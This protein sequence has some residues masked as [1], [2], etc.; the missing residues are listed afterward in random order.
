MIQYIFLAEVEADE[1][2]VNE[3]TKA[4]QGMREAIP[5]IVDLSVGVNKTP[6]KNSGFNWGVTIRFVDWEARKAYTDHPYHRSIGDKYGH[7]VKEKI[8][9]NFEV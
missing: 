7:I 1:E 6:E 3:V 9:T 2:T 4:I 5:G 8:A